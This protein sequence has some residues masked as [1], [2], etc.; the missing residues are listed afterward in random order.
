M[1]FPPVPTWKAQQLNP[2]RLQSKNHLL[3]VAHKP[4]PCLIL[5]VGSCAGENVA[6]QQVRAD[7]KTLVE[8]YLPRLLAANL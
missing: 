1:L 4:T 3:V 5:R 2:G 8:I 6:T 7:S